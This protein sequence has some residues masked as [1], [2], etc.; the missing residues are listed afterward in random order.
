MPE[1]QLNTLK[2]PRQKQV[3][4][5]EWCRNLGASRILATGWERAAEGALINK[6][7][8][9]Y[10]DLVIE[11]W[12]KGRAKPSRQSHIWNLIDKEEDLIQV[13]LESF[14]YV[15]GVIHD[16]AY[17]NG[18]ARVLGKR[19]EYVLWLCHPQWG[20]S[21]HLEGLR[22]ASGSDLGMELMTKRLRDKGFKKASQYE[23]LK[24]VERTALGW[25][26]LECIEHGTRLIESYIGTEAGGRRK[27]RVRATPLFWEFLSN[28]KDIVR[29]LRPVKLPMM[30][31]PKDWTGHHSGGYL[32]IET[33]LTPVPW[34]EFNKCWEQTLPCVLNSTNIS[35]R[36]EFQLDPEMLQFLRDVWESGHSVGKVPSSNR[37]TAPKDQDF[38]IRGLGPSAYWK[39][40]W[41]Y[42][43]DAR[44]NST[45]SQVISGLA[46]TAQF[47]KT[48][49]IYFVNKQD[50][51]GR[52][53]TYGGQ[54]NPQ[55]SEHFRALIQFKKDSLMKG[56]EAAF[57][58]SLG[59]AF[60]VEAN[61]K[62]RMDF[63]H[64]ERGGIRAAGND[65]LGQLEFIDR[66]KEPFR[67]T[68]LCM[69]WACYQE[70]PWYRTGTIHW[71]DQTCS[72]WGHVACLTGDGELAQYTNITGTRP[73]DLYMGIGLLVDRHI[74]SRL[75]LTEVDGR[76]RQYLE[77]WAA[78]PVP[79]SLH[80]Q[81]FMPVIYGRSFL[82]LKQ[83]IKE[84]LRDEVEDFLTDEGYRVTDLAQVFAS[85]AHQTVRKNFP[86]IENLARWLGN[87]GALQMKKGIRPH[88]MTPNRLLVQSY[89]NVTEKEYVDLRVANRSVR[90]EQR[91]QNKKVFNVAR[92]KRKMVP[93]YVHSMDAAFLQ[94]FVC[95]WHEAYGHPLST[96]HDCFGT[97]LGSVATLRK[98]LN[99][100]WSRF[101]SEDHL[102]RHKLATEISLQCQLPDPPVVGTLDR[103]RVG[104]N[105]Y[106]FC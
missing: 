21:K 86:N 84:Y 10:L 79:R 47:D 3:E 67:F 39:A 46:L 76:E 65:P 103:N 26:F 33:Q 20:G 55:S 49:S 2:S 52:I 63:L 97:T 40:L 80:K 90:V 82:S 31:P 12:K 91:G 24:P 25:I 56:N 1:Q 28:Y 58:W 59:E 61:E 69:D 95:H 60:G 88:W 16:S 29:W 72:G 44:Q 22:L 83:T 8:R 18:L 45:R 13:A 77:W 106:L 70:N 66:A 38:K 42:K 71:L 54:I 78:H 57:A 87:I 43:S 94:R 50:H 74:E 32:G 68:Q 75:Q 96:V 6:L 30:V 85:A 11:G 73:A 9:V 105:P 48:G 51:R 41:K 92:T 101:Y 34:E 64:E 17:G 23:P 102:A 62:A 93:D 99:D 81:M 104:E 53:Y 5:E 27:R 98:E 15:L 7:S 89:S 19:A 4:L 35:Q 37:L 100:Q 36:Q 14:V